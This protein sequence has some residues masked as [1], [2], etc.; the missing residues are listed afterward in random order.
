MAFGAGESFSDFVGF[1]FVRTFIDWL[2]RIRKFC[3]GFR[4]SLRNRF[5]R[6][7]SFVDRKIVPRACHDGGLKLTGQDLQ[8]V[9]KRLGLWSEADG[10]DQYVGENCIGS[11]E[12]G[13]LFD[14]GEASFEE[15]KDAF[16][17]F[18]EDGDGSVGAEDLQRVLRNL[19]FTEGLRLEECE[20]MI[21]VHDGNGDG[22]VDLQDFA[23]LMRA[24]PC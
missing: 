1:F 19:G 21:G 12:I 10:S 15:L 4:S 2:F 24:C 5:H 17:V 8:V 23:K 9:M 16:E 11:D 7:P 22:R 20:R 6:S 13:E 18:D 3:E 14:E